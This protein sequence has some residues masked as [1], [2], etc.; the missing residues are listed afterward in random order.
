MKPNPRRNKLTQ[1]RRCLTFGHGSRN[2]NVAEKCSKCS[3]NHPTSSCNETEFQCANCGGEHDASSPDC[4]KRKS[5]LEMR[6]KLSAKSNK[7]K[8]ISTQV[9]STKSSADF[10]ELPQ[11]KPWSLKKKPF[12]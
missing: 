5:F 3:K 12:I 2:C 6:Q 10:P 1:C 4:P 8:G 11:N 7:P 9:P